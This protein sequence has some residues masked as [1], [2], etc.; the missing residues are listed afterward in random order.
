MCQVVICD[1]CILGALE[2]F[3]LKAGGSMGSE[4]TG[5]FLCSIHSGSC[6]QI[7]LLCLILSTDTLPWRLRAGQANFV[8][9]AWH[10]LWME[11]HP[12]THTLNTLLSTSYGS[13]T[14]F[15]ANPFL[16][17]LGCRF[18]FASQTL[19]VLSTFHN[20]AVCFLVQPG[21]SWCLLW[22]ECLWQPP[23]P[24]N[25][26]CW[27]LNAQCIRRWGLLIKSWGWNLHAWD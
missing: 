14:V 18:I 26:I 6:V 25:F 11:T 9:S 15:A 2:V 20:N 1:P 22:S 13:W 8:S 23:T 16:V 10:Q 17:D 27:K 21:N 24:T 3:P 12:L 7:S 4:S 5:W 19:C